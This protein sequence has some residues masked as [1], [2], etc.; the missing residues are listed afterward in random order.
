[1]R[2]LMRGFAAGSQT[3]AANQISGRRTMSFNSAVKKLWEVLACS[4]LLASIS[5]GQQLTGTLTGTTFDSTGAAVPNAKVTM[6]NESSGDTRSTVSNDSGYFSITA[7]Q[8]G[9]YTVIVNA[10]GFKAWQEGHIVFS[11]GGNLTMPNIKLQV[12][13]VNETVEISAGADAVVPVDTAEVSTTL[14][15]GLLEYVPI[16]G[17]DAGELL[18][19][20]PGIALNNGGTQGSSFNPTTVGSHNGPVGAHSAKG[21]H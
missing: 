20:M 21:T 3:F 17:R 12:G 4:L 14:N 2:A 11:Q 7:V 6:K 8:P 19:L 1:M 13:Q 16:V 15:T 5:F 18:K 9:S 10:P